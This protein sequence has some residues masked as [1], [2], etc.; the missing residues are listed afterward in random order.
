[1]CI[2]GFSSKRDY[3]LSIGHVCG[4]R[5]EVVQS[6]QSNV[7]VADRRKQLS[8]DLDDKRA[9]DLRY[10][11]NNLENAYITDVMIASAAK[12]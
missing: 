5:G 7:T 10:V 9:G 11:C 6:I 3:G 8:A 1:M 12:A 4:R 2:V